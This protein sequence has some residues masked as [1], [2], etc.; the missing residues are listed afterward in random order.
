MTPTQGTTAPPDETGTVTATSVPAAPRPLAAG[1]GF[2]P[3]RAAAATTGSTIDIDARVPYFS[4][5]L[6]QIGMIA[7]ALV[8]VIIV[9]SFLLK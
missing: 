7:G 4:R 8:V 5:D 3:R 1:S 9:A 6:Q 2:A